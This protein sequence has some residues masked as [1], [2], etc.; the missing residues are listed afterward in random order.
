VI[1]GTL[2]PDFYTAYTTPQLEG[3]LI[4]TRG[5]GKSRTWFTHQSQEPTVRVIRPPEDHD[6]EP[7]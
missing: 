4:C 6:R 3:A 2:W 1:I 5:N 7:R